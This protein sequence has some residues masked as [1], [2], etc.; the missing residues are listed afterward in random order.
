[1]PAR[2]AAE[3]RAAGADRVET[4]GFILEG[5]RGAASVLALTGEKGITRRRDLFH[6]SGLALATLFDWAEDHELTI[7]AQWHT[8]GRR[9]F[10]SDTDLEYGFNVSGFTT[11]VVPYFRQA[12]PDAKH[13][14]WWIF[15]SG[16]WVA[17]PAPESV[18]GSFSVI[19]F[20]EGRVDEH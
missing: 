8:H 16:E 4:G 18:P 15:D 3:A 17:V 11:T 20:E 12:S 5:E 19:T 13:W 9:A 2:I 1:M 14:G 7:A 6:V 10:L